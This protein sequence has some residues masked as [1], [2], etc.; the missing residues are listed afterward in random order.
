MTMHREDTPRDLA[1]SILARLSFE[2]RMDAYE[3]HDEATRARKLAH[4]N[5]R[6]KPLGWAY[7]FALNMRRSRRAW[8]TYAAAVRRGR[9]LVS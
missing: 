2:D 8:R 6:N 1:L 9:G 7:E 5:R 4:W 3:L